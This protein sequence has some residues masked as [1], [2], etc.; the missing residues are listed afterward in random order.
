MN[1]SDAV[2]EIR[3]KI[4]DRDEVGFDDE[5]I[6][7]YLNEA[8]SSVSTYL[9]SINS[10]IMVEEI[11]INDKECAIPKN[12]AKMAGGFPLKRT[13]NKF[14]LLTEPPVKLRY[15][16]AYDRLE[17]DEDMPFK[18]AALNQVCIKLACVFANAQQH[19]DITQDKALLDEM[20]AIVANIG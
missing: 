9:I 19:L 15:L 17:L 3:N 20:N 13:G 18:Y 5:E 14:K 2:I 8:I 7:S 4:N 6:L 10:P 16:V 1:V 11:V 12:F